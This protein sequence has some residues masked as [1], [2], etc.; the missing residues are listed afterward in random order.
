VREEVSIALTSSFASYG[1]SATVPAAVE[2][3]AALPASDS[4][5]ETSDS[6]A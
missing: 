2:A 6:A 1:K 5:M 3:A 4:A